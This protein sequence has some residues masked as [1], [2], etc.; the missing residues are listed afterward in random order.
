MYTGH[1]AH[2]TRSI[3]D[4]QLDEYHKRIK[5]CPF[6]GAKAGDI[7]GI[8]FGLRGDMYFSITCIPCSVTMID[9]RTDKVI[10]KWNSRIK[11]AG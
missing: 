5:P 1:P 3:S 8:W 4:E 7:E 6:C 2:P 9:D 11:T 10:G